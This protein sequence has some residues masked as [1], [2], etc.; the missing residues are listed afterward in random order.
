MNKKIKKNKNKMD[1]EEIKEI[2]ELKSAYFFI[3]KDFDMIFES[4][5]N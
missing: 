2:E 5:R 3:C 4:K 1:V